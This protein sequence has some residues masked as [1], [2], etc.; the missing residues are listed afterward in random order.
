MTYLL[1]T[2]IFITAFFVST[3]SSLPYF[4]V[5]SGRPKCVELDGAVEKTK[6]RIHYEAPGMSPPPPPPLL[7]GGF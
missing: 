3:V 7:S 1:R 4:I 6:I 5:Q 2:L